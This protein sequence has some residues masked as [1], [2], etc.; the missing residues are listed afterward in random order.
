MS[1]FEW[2]CFGF[3]FEEFGLGK[4]SRFRFRKNLVSEKSLGFSFGKFGIVKKSLGIGFGQIFGIVIQC[5]APLGN[6]VDNTW[7]QLGA[8]W[9]QLD[10]TWNFEWTTLGH[11]LEQIGIL[12]T[13]LRST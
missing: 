1:I 13:A 3:G 9:T 2:F 5:L 8:T 6:F 12:C 7:A 4:K 10:T 11:Q